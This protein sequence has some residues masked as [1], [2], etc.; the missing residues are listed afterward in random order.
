M[1]T[2]THAAAATER[3]NF[4]TLFSGAALAL[5]A[6]ATG[7]LSLVFLRPRVTYGPPS[8]LAVGKADAFDPGT[9]VVLPE[10]K[11]VIRRVGDR[12]AAISTVCTHLGC[13]VSPTE[14]GFDCPCHGSQ[15]DERGDVIG[16][17]A[18]KS[19]SWFEITVAPNGDLVVDKHRPV[20]ADTFLGLRS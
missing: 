11:I 16:G 20:A 12:V 7:A 19:L 4:L 2:P 17:P 3:R 14:T 6:A 1:S 9:Q 18:P 13:T 10:H 15:Y 8:R 5:W